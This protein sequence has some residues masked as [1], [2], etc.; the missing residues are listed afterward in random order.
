MVRRSASKRKAA[1]QSKKSVRDKK[2][3][4]DDTESSESETIDSRSKRRR[5]SS[6]KAEYDEENEEK[7]SMANSKSSPSRYVNPDPAAITR[8]NLS[9]TE[10]VIKDP[11]DLKLSRI[12]ENILHL[13]ESDRSFAEKT[14]LVLDRIAAIRKGNSGLQNFSFSKSQICHC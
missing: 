8:N 12:E 7:R 5:S 10:E 3:V 11:R 4:D 6:S 14:D 9:I 1:T 13:K 2:I